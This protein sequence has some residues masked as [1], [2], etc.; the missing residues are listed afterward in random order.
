MQKA[1]EGKPISKLAAVL[2][3]G[4]RLYHCVFSEGPDGLKAD[5]PGNGCNA[6]I[7]DRVEMLWRCPSGFNRLDA[8]VESL[9]SDPF[10]TLIMSPT[11]PVRTTGLRKP[12][13]VVPGTVKC[14]LHWNGRAVNGQLIDMSESGVAVKASVAIPIESEVHV[15]ADLPSGRR[16]SASGSVRHCT[17]TVA[18]SHRLGICFHQSQPALL[19]P[20]REESGGA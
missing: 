17:G 14:L 13:S 12:R 8:V 9:T 19:S 11:G 2:R 4:E 16:L 5:I 1:G 6:G 20:V 18:R 15:V 3:H 10:V 7:G